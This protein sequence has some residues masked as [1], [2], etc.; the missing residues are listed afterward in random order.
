MDVTGMS[1]GEG[2]ALEQVQSAAP[3]SAPQ[4]TAAA[5]PVGLAEPTAR[6]GEP[7]TAGATAGPGPGP[8]EIG[9]ASNDDEEIRQKLGPMLPVLMR[10]ADAP[11]ASASYKRQVR[12]LIARITR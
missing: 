11:Y 5:P 9:L 4:R 6:P 7:V 1:Y 10:M 3:L 2:Q 12:Q 8:G